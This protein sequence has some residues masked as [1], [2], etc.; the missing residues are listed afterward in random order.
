MLQSFFI[1]I[2]CFLF[3][4]S[5]IKQLSPWRENVITYEDWIYLWE[6]SKKNVRIS[7]TNKGCFFY[8]IHGRQ[9]T[10]GN[11]S[12]KERDYEKGLIVL[13]VF[14][15]QYLN[16]DINIIRKLKAGRALYKELKGIDD[17]KIKLKYKK[18]LKS[19]FLKSVDL[20]WR[21]YDKLAGITNQSS[22][23]KHYGTSNSQDNF[24]RYKKCL[25]L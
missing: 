23:P 16:K 5:C 10:V 11:L 3:K 17:D 15:A 19:K 21:F 25:K 14:E 2:P 4:R 7:H 20:I 13:P 6:I 8:M 24:N 9:S 1:A 22:W 18:Y 12:N